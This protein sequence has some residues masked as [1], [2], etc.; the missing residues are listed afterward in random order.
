MDFSQFLIDLIFQPG[1]SLKLIPA[2]N[3]TVLCLLILMA[4]LLYSSIDVIHIVVMSTLSV[5]LL[6]SVNWWV[7]SCIFWSPFPLPPS[8]HSGFT[9]S[10]TKFLHQT[11]LRK[12]ART[13]WRYLMYICAYKCEMFCLI[14][15]WSN[16]SSVILKN[17]LCL[18]NCAFVQLIVIGQTIKLYMETLNR[19]SSS[20]FSVKTQQISLLY[21]IDS[22]TDKS[23]SKSDMTDNT[24]GIVS[25]M[26]TT[27]THHNSLFLKVHFI[28]MVHI[29]SI[30][31]ITVYTTWVVILPQF[32]PQSY[33]PISTNRNHRFTS[34]QLLML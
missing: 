22:K 16:A 17:L 31:R 4:F 23:R 32:N 21:S 2:I 18:N 7:V 28:T 8:E 25:A 24:A 26:C 34:A 5:G 29:C 12:Q 19:I 11:K 10:T 15:I 33:H 30:T 20:Q 13:S 9:W 3:I 1:S 14:W 27:S 6:L